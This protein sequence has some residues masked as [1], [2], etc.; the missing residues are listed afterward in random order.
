[1]TSDDD[2]MLSV[3]ESKEDHPRLFKEIVFP[4]VFETILKN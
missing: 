2:K 1:M 3:Q 4:I